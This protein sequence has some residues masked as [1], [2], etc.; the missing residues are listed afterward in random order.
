MEKLDRI[1]LLA[2][3]LALQVNLPAYLGSC[4]ASRS[5]LSQLISGLR[6]LLSDAWEGGPEFAVLV[7]Q[8][9]GLLM[10]LPRPER[11]SVRRAEQSVDSAGLTGLGAKH[12]ASGG[13][14]QRYSKV[15]LSGEEEQTTNQILSAEANPMSGE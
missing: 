15:S 4:R 1:N 6:L 14:K 8:M 5:Q 13:P 2:T 11:Q 3:R 9:R 10:R 12:E 7:E